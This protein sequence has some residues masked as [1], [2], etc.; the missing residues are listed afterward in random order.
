MKQTYQG[1]ELLLVDD[2]S[3]DKS[4]SICD[5]LAESDERIKVYHKTNSGQFKTRIFGIEKS[6][7]RYVLFL[8]SDDKYKECLLEKVYD[9]V[10]A[11]EADLVAWDIENFGDDTD[12]AHSPLSVNKIIGQK[13]YIKSIIRETNNSMCN[14][15][16]KGS[17]IR[18]T[19][20]EN[21]D[22]GIRI[23]ED[24]MQIMSIMCHIKSII[25]L[26]EALYLYRQIDESI[27]HREKYLDDIIDSVRSS[28][29]VQDTLKRYGLL[30]SDIEE[31]EYRSFLRTISSRVRKGIL[32][33]TL[34][35]K[36]CKVVFLNEYYR[37]SKKSETVSNFGLRKYLILRL[38][39]L[40]W[41]TCLSVYLKLLSFKSRVYG[42]L[43]K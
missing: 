9:A 42:L 32:N 21:F 4:G 43:N 25:Y 2:G 1:W 10:I 37:L 36:G 23:A 18:K 26:G 12:V 8:D 35:K 16:I 20:Y 5:E 40:R 24:Y 19:R 28:E 17:I 7:G 30:D 41:F 34:K 14:K 27:S 31:E 39:R 6:V 11:F 33:H 29:Y 13:E 3:T 38:F 22:D 15:A